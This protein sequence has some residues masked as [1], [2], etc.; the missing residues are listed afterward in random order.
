MI[1]SK[2][3]KIFQSSKKD[4][5]GIDRYILTSVSGKDGRGQITQLKCLL[6]VMV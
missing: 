5:W 4:I 1:T 2:S 6:Y 3:A